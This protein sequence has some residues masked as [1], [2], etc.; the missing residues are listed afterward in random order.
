MSRIPEP[1]RLARRRVE[2][3]LPADVREEVL[4]DLQEV[5]GRRCASHGPRRARLWYAS[6]AVSFSGR[7]LMD[8][9]RAGWGGVGERNGS[10]AAAGT[11]RGPLVRLG[12]SWLDFKLGFRMLLKYP[13]LTVVGGVA[14]AFAI[15]VGAG[16]FEFVTQVVRPTL[17]LDDGDRIVGI[18]LWHSASGGVEEQALYDFVGWREAVKSVVDLG[19][20]RTLRRNVIVNGSGTEET[21]AAISASAFRVARVPPL[22]GRPLVEADERPGA[23]PVI[24]IGYDVWQRRFDGD[25]DVVGRTV[26]L[27]NT[28]V[29]V[30]GVMPEGFAFPVSHHVWT[31]LRLDLIDFGRRSGPSVNVFGRLASG[32][33]IGEAQAELAALGQRASADF[34]DTHEHIRPQVLPYA[35]SILNFTRGQSVGLM[36]V[37]NLFV[38]ALLVVMCANVALLMFARATTREGEIVVRNALGASRGRI[39]TQL[40]VEALVVGGVGTIVGLALARFGLH[41]GFAAVVAE[42]GALPFWFRPSL[43]PATVLYAAV[44]TLVGAMVAG[45]APALK[46]TRG[47]GTAAAGDRGRWRAAVQRAL[48]R[49]DRGAGRDHRRV[50]CRRLLRAARRSADRVARGPLPGPRVS[51]AAARHG[52]ERRLGRGRG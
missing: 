10:M 42:A 39:I 51:F 22:L 40:F 29:T 35:S 34:P 50:P 13:G 36:S 27:A 4:G 9:L 44:L 25:P 12:V 32:V 46:V 8:R 37:A 47:L 5:F 33:T 20:F 1:P 41:W 45:A 43:S 14:I 48:D 23:A 52:P 2:R 19:A 18:R 7:F 31:P 16:T 49:G 11:G 21:V 15:W 38:V 17:P 30:V 26:R 6:Q 24:V 28:A 3:A